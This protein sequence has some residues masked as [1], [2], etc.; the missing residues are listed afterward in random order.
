MSL[1]VSRLNEKKINEIL[2]KKYVLS[3][4]SIVRMPNGSANLFHVSSNNGDY[5]LK[6]FQDGFDINRVKREIKITELVQNGGIPTTDFI[7]NCDRQ[8]Y[9]I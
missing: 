4:N 7:Y 3:C 9:L 5:V 2:N 8:A 6:E 1:N